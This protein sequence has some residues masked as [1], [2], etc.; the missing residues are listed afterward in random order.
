MSSAELYSINH[1]TAITR[2]PRW[3]SCLPP[4]EGNSPALTGYSGNSKA[5]SIP[6]NS[7]I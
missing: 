6:K 1:D 4:A 7:R 5:N 3:I 2:T